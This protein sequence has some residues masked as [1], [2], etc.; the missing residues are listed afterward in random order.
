MAWGIEELRGIFYVRT[1]P[2]TE[3]KG[4]AAAGNIRE[5]QRKVILA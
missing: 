4:E 5:K 3:A 2:D 1:A